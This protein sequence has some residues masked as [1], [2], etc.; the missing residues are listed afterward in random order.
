MEEIRLESGI[1]LGFLARS[2]V[3]AF[4]RPIFGCFAYLSPPRWVLGVYV[5][6]PRGDSRI[7]AGRYGVVK[8][9]KYDQNPEF[10]GFLT[11]S[12]FSFVAAPSSAVSRI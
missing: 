2:L 11:R 4:R 5:R 10:L 1:F 6:L 9:R 3:F 12:L 7:P 8:W